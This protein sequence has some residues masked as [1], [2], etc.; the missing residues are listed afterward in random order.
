MTHENLEDHKNRAEE[1]HDSLEKFAEEEADVVHRMRKIKNDTH[2]WMDFIEK[3][4]G[5]KHG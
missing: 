2:E 4:Y 3:H 1:F 5:S